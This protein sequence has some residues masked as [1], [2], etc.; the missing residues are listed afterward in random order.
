MDPSSGLC[1]GCLRTLDE[2]AR[3]GGMA[4][5]RRERVM[6]ALP[7]RAARLSDTAQRRRDAI[8]RR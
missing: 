3:W 5:A 7:D 8:N 2:I 1:V 4:E 6:R